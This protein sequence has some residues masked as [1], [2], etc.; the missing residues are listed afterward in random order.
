MKLGLI[1]RAWFAFQAASFA[2]TVIEETVAAHERRSH[3]HGYTWAQVE[4]I[5]GLCFQAQPDLHATVMALPE[6]RRTAVLS[7]ILTCHPSVFR[8]HFGF[9]RPNP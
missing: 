3:P 4:H 8:K 1:G 7:G 9:D 6:P 5:Y 2:K